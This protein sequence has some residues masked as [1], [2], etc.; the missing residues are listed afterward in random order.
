LLRLSQLHRDLG[1]TQPGQDRARPLLLVIARH[2]WRA[3]GCARLSRR[4]HRSHRHQHRP[5]MRV[6]PLRNARRWTAT[7]PSPTSRASACPMSTARSST[8]MMTS[9]EAPAGSSGFRSAMPNG[10]EARQDKRS[11]ASPHV[12]PW[13]HPTPSSPLEDSLCT[14]LHVYMLCSLLFIRLSMHYYI[15][16]HQF[17]LPLRHPTPIHI[18]YVPATH[19]RLRPR[20]PS[21]YSIIV[22]PRLYTV[23]AP[24]IDAADR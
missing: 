18:T 13:T 2:R 21:L 20:T 1:L 17:A 19:T 12:P 4:S 22:F 14:R 15:F 6:L 23:H 5:S 3:K 8:S 9:V 24:S 11:Y 7:S 16:W 10:T